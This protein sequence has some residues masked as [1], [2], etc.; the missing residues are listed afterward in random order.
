MWT[1]YSVTKVNYLRLQKI[2][3]SLH[4]FY[5]NLSSSNTDDLIATASWPESKSYN[6]DP[7]ID[8]YQS[9][10]CQLLTLF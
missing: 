2:L 8:R 4:R 5:N 10:S 1:I 3:R 7:Y 9:A 6:L